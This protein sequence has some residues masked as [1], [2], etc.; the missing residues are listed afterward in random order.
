MEKSPVKAIRSY[1]I[2]CSG[3]SVKEVRLCECVNC[4]LWPF[5]FGINPYH[6]K[7][8]KAEKKPQNE[9]FSNKGEALI[10]DN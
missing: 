1:C 2:D 6:G 3:N 9:G 10:Y 8:K 4:A 5:R 7:G